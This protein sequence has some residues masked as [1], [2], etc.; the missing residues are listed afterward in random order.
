[1]L[2]LS[3]PGLFWLCCARRINVHLGW[4]KCFARKQVEN[5][6]TE[7]AFSEMEFFV[8]MM[9]RSFSAASSCAP[10]RCGRVICSSADTRLFIFWWMC[11]R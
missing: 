2:D 1:M 6:K 4:M 10:Q 3:V 8:M 7:P 9:I 5:N 11:V